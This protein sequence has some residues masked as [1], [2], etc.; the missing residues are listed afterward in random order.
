LSL[1]KQKAMKRLEKK[2]S[3]YHKVYEQLYEYPLIS[4]LK[5]G[6]NT[7]IPRSTV[8]AYILQM[9]ELSILKGPLIFLKPAKDY[10]EYVHFLTFENP[11]F[12]YQYLKDFPHVISRSLTSGGW[13]VLLI[14]EKM[15]D[16]SILKGFKQCLLKEAKGATHLSKVTSLDWEESLKRMRSMMHFPEEKSFLYEEIPTISWRPEEW[17]LYN[18]L[19]YNV[20][21]K[22]KNILKKCQIRYEL[23]QNW[24]PGLSQFANIQA[25]FYPH[26]TESYLFLDFLFRSEYQKQLADILGQLPSTSVFFSVGDYLFARLS[27]LNIL[28][29]KLLFSFI[30]ELQKKGFL[31][32]FH[33]AAVSSTSEFGLDI[34]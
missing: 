13:N 34:R 15:M 12:T 19:K 31:T 17:T 32:D 8:S 33:Q 23:Y 21:T 1:T 27:V 16:F 20:R 3:R 9:Y 5:I 10:H 30:F 11:L 7:E 4:T 6:E 26:G 2:L 24:I 25:A 14:C 29:V 18:R 22:K 28:E